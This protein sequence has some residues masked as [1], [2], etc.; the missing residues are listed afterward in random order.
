MIC[1]VDDNQ[2]A[3]DFIINIMSKSSEVYPDLQGKNNF[4]EKE[5]VAHIRANLTAKDIIKVDK[6]FNSI[7]NTSSLST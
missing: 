1:R 6:V 5:V 2:E 4:Y 3:E 7:K